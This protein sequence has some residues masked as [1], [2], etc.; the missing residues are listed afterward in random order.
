MPRSCGD[1]NDGRESYATH[2]SVSLAACSSI[3]ITPPAIAAFHLG[4]VRIYSYFR[5]RMHILV[6]D[7][8]LAWPCGTVASR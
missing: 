2:A 6:S 8:E 5:E 1:E 4:V 3:E 7:R